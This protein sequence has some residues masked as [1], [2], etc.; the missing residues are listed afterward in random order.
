MKTIEQLNKLTSD[1]LLEIVQNLP[2]RIF[3][4]REFSALENATRVTV[5][6]NYPERMIV[7][8]VES[9]PSDDTIELLYSDSEDA[10]FK[11]PVFI[12]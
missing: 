3:G 11:E 2:V 12:G 4:F 8:M 5:N 1:E 10:S 7:L 6:E 9:G